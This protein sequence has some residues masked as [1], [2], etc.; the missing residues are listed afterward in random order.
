MCMYYNM[1]NNS[2]I[3][4]NYIVTNIIYIYT[5]ISRCLIKLVSELLILGFFLQWVADTT[6]PVYS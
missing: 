3:I 6:R 4:H 5:Y 1:Y 2:I